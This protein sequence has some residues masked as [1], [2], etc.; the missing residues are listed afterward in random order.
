MPQRTW[1]KVG[2]S[3]VI[4]ALAQIAISCHSVPGERDL[5]TRGELIPG[6]RQFASMEASGDFILH[7]GSEE[8]TIRCD[9]IPG[10]SGVDTARSIETTEDG[11]P[12]ARL[13]RLITHF[14]FDEP[15]VLIEQNPH[16]ESYGTL[17]GD[18]V[19]AA[20]ALLPGTATFHQ[21]IYLTLEGQ[22]LANR[23]PLTMT[24]RNVQAWP[25]VGAE[26]R[27]EAP[28]DF[29]LLEDLDNPEAQPLATL[30]ACNTPVLARIAMPD[31]APVLRSSRR[32]G[33]HR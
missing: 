15:A 1:L 26:F 21:F 9:R 10:I 11:R 28:T 13:R 25:P 2:T 12:Q 23:E 27:T 32:L 4:G 18:R 22:V 5:L 16:K 3:L 24:A 17:T 7:L 8:E 6:S 14:H 30:S 33:G 20:Q 29:Y 31:S 19:G